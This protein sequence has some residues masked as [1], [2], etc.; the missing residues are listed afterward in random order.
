MR[1]PRVLVFS[2]RHI[3]RE[4]NNAD[5][6]LRLTTVASETRDPAALSMYDNE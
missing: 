4:Q 3:G 5:E 2:Q 1:N 6:R